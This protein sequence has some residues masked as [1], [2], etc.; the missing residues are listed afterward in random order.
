MTRANFV[1]G[2]GGTNTPAFQASLTNSLTLADVT[3]TDIVFNSEL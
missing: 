2:I 1:S 3:N